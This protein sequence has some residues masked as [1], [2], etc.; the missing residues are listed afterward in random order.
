MVL[1]WVQTYGGV[2]SHI[3]SGQNEA[4]LV[5]VTVCDADFVKI[6]ISSPRTGNTSNKKKCSG[7]SPTF[8]IQG[9]LKYIIDPRFLSNKGSSCFLK[10]S[11]YC[12]EH[13]YCISSA[14]KAYKVVDRRELCASLYEH[15]SGRDQSRQPTFYPCQL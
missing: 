4:V 1:L 2:R 7:P 5:E 6:C 12:L 11:Y 8:H 9:Y 10:L 15:Q 3:R 14:K 13:R